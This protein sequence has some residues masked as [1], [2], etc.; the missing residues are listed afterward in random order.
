MFYRTNIY[1]PGILLFFQEVMLLWIFHLCDYFIIKKVFLG[2]RIF[3]ACQTLHSNSMFFLLK[4]RVTDGC[5]KNCR[6]KS[7]PET[8]RGGLFKNSVEAR[9]IVP[10]RLLLISVSWTLHPYCW[11]F[12]F[13]DDKRIKSLTKWR[14]LFMYS[15]A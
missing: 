3:W 11:F 5:S 6:S 13:I 1:F 9:Q 10:P 7:E 8:R 2:V 15:F 14:T 12:S 4:L